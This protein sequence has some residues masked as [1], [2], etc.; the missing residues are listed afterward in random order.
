MTS[1]DVGEFKSGGGETLD[2]IRQFQRREIELARDRV[3]DV[4]KVLA[5]S[6][7]RF[8]VSTIGPAPMLRPRVVI[9]TDDAERAAHV[10]DSI[11]GA[12][13][14]W[15]APWLPRGFNAHRGTIQHHVF[16]AGWS[17]PDCLEGFADSIGEKLDERYTVETGDEG[18]GTWV[19]HFS[20]SGT[21]FKAAGFYV[22]G[23]CIMTWWK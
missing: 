10:Y 5:F 2:A 20:A 11:D 14:P 13:R 21:G 22:P 12:V 1:A 18:P 17:V 3:G 15:A 6:Q 19:A 4:D 7:G 23:G 9:E 8:T 16:A